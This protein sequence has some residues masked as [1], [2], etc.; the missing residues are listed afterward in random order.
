M[1]R[2]SETIEVV[3]GQADLEARP[4][5]AD[6][7]DIE[8]IVGSVRAQPRVDRRTGTSRSRLRRPADGGAHLM[9]Y[10]GSARVESAGAVIEVPQGMGTAVPE[11]EPPP[12]A[13]P[14]LPAPRLAEPGRDA[15]IGFT[16]P[17][18]SWRAVD[19]A[20][21]YTVE[22]CTDAACARLVERLVGV[23]DTRVISPPLP[24]GRV[25][26]RVTAVSASGLDGQPAATVGFDVTSDQ[27]DLAP[28]VVVLVCERPGAVSDPAALVVRPGERFR[29]VAHDDASG[30]DRVRFRWDGGEWQVAGN[31]WQ[32]VPDIAGVH[33]LEVTARDHSG[34]A[35]TPWSVEVRVDASSPPPP[36][37][38]VVR[39]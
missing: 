25:F 37:V 36:A 23:A 5:R 11:G 3:E 19:G 6:D 20:V 1:G 7:D 26:W 12:P 34:R 24:Q 9:V 29:L 28:P 18:L 15:E 16:T 10:G 22:M 4:R 14:L 38:R 32:A 27:P 2:T 31:G 21:S 30:V 8:V 13:E 39:E 17:L 33:R 35:A